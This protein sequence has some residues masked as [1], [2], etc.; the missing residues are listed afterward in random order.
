[1][2]FFFGRKAVNLACGLVLLGMGL[3][4]TLRAAEGDP[5]TLR[6]VAEAEVARARLK[7]EERQHSAAI[8]VQRGNEFLRTRQYQSA[9]EQFMLARGLDPDNAEAA[10][11][12]TEALRYLEARPESG[13]ITGQMVSQERVR[14]EYSIAGINQELAMARRYYAEA[15]GSLEGM[16]DEI[17]I[18]QIAQQRKS[19]G[20]AKSSALRA[21]LSIESLAS[22]ASMEVVRSEVIKLLL[23]IDA[24]DKAL[25]L[26]LQDIGTRVAL[27]QV[28]QEK[29]L[30]DDIEASRRNTMLTQAKEYMAKQRFDE[31]LKTLQELLRINPVDAEAKRLIELCRRDEYHSRDVL[32]NEMLREHRR[33]AL[34]NIERNAIAEVSQRMPLRFPKNWEILVKQKEMSTETEVVSEAMQRTRRR[35]ESAYSFEFVETEF[36]LILETIR[37][38][39]DLNIVVDRSVQSGDTPV[40]TE[41]YTFSFRNMRLDNIF[42]W[43]MRS[44]GLRY[45]INQNGI[46]NITTKDLSLEAATVEVYDIRDIAF[47][48]TNAKRMP[49]GSEE[50]EDDD[51]DE[52]LGAEDTITLGEILDKFINK[53]GAAPEDTKIE[54]RE[55][56][57]LV[58]K[59]TP[60]IRDQVEKLLEQLRSAQTIQVS[61]SARFLTLTDNFWE[62]FR[63]EFMD[64]N[65]TANGDITEQK[66]LSG[67]TAGQ[68]PNKGFGNPT[69][70]A[71][72]SNN[73]G[74]PS[75]GQQA[76][77]Q[78]QY[79]APGTANANFSP[80]TYWSQ[81]A[82]SFFYGTFE[83]LSTVFGDRADMS[84]VNNGG[85]IAQVQQLGWLGGLQSQW[86]IQMIRESDRADELFNPHLVVYN[87]RYGWIRFIDRY[88]YVS[89][90]RQGDGGTGIQPVISYIDEG[91]SL[92]IRPNVSSDRKYITVDARPRVIRVDN[93]RTSYTTITGEVSSPLGLIGIFG[94]AVETPTVFRHDAGT[95]AIIPDGGAIMITGLATNVNARGRNG[96]PLISELPVIGNAFSSRFYQKDKRSYAC[97]LNA[98]MIILDEEEARQTGN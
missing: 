90:Y 42:N 91:C 94:Y 2:N 50:D 63:S 71:P 61:V 67:G 47:A 98:R 17:K 18:R 40:L 43:L 27:S 88:P 19:L 4:D 15:T 1:M 95:Y 60:E 89:T 72:G 16:A 54:V 37:N 12:R 29:R 76:A 20:E 41:A 79:L 22:P 48:V 51:D 81:A 85:L 3:G 86:F 74:S 44:T 6:Q 34:A 68:N 87:N 82:G 80:G 13:S 31:A 26:E 32:I 78:D 73:T 45:N 75:M 8:H 35:L 59:A 5:S 30:V 39:T 92:Q 23:D 46:I 84:G 25:A 53:E 21:K 14:Q 36:Q 65:N 10:A 58:I 33:L 69:I 97:L 62:Q 83:G 64:W 55:D 96:I 28:E 66:N 24:R 9:L 7:Q 49:T 52:D 70:F 77:W 11:G 56:G 93:K 57:H 38:R